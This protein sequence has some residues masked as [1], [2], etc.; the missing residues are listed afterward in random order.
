MKRT[1]LF[2]CCAF[3]LMNGLNAQ[4]RLGLKAGTNL[5]YFR[6]I[7]ASDESFRRTLLVGP[8]GGFCMQVP[9]FKQWYFHSELL[10]IEK[11]LGLSYPSLDSE[12]TIEKET[13]GYVALPV[14]M[15][16]K[17]AEK[18]SCGAGAEFSYAALD[19]GKRFILHDQAFD[20]A[21]LGQIRY[22]FAERMDATFRYTHGLNPSS[23]VLYADYNGVEVERTQW[24]LASWQ[25]SLGWWL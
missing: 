17:W 20:V 16:W 5:S 13:L 18:L 19:F 24:L 22:Q 15:E 7:S 10:Y 4:L 6:D 3:A 23:E 11:H 12:R 2:V 25:L 8:L 21:L 9:V 14:F 1:M